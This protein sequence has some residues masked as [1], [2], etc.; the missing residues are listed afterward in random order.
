MLGND[1]IDLN[2]LERV[3]P[4]IVTLLG[5]SRIKQARE[6]AAKQWEAVYGAET[7]HTAPLGG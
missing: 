3:L 4:H 6:Q 5:D 7:T 2:E 1:A